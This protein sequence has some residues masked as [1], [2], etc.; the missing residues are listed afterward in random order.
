MDFTASFPFQ[1]SIVKQPK[2]KALNVIASDS[3]SDVSDDEQD[4]KIHPTAA[5]ETFVQDSFETSEHKESKTSVV[6]KHFLPFHTISLP[7]NRS[8]SS[9][10]NFLMCFLKGC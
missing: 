6:L 1:D 3:E 10:N 2:K 5:A 9:I 4:A 8:I 7:D